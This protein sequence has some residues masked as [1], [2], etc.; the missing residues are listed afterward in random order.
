M[1]G[2]SAAHAPSTTSSRPLSVPRVRGTRNRLPA[3]VVD[4]VIITSSGLWL[5]RGPRRRGN[6][7]RRGCTQLCCVS[8]APGP[9]GGR[10]PGP[11]CRAGVTGV[12]YG[13]DRALP[14]RR[15]WLSTE[16]PDS[17]A[18]NVHPSPAPDH[19]RHPGAVP[20]GAD[21]LRSGPVEHLPQQPRPA[22]GGA[23]PARHRRRR[24]RRHRRGVERLHCDWSDPTRIVITDTDSTVWGGRSRYVY[25]LTARP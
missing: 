13:R 19:Q 11:G 8:I 14:A 15:W 10:A 25:T 7:S 24:H 16:H 21:R 22:P 4:S 5:P 2:T 23:L 6:A 18:D 12:F 1:N 9:T 20:G 17:G 3:V